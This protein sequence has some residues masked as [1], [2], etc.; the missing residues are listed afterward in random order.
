VR[1]ACAE[2]AARYAL[3]VPRRRLR[4]RIGDALGSGPGASV[5]FEDHRDY[6]I[7]DDPRHID[8]RAYARS[9]RLSVRVW[10]EEVAPALDLVVDTSASMAVSERK[11]RAAR[12]LVDAVAGW[13]ARDGAALR[14]FAAG[15]DRLAGAEALA[16]AGPGTASLAPRDT[17]RPRG[18]RVVVSDFLFEEDPAP[19]LRRLV[20]G[21]AHVFVIQL[22]DPDE[23]APD[24]A[25]LAVTLVD[26]ERGGR[27]DLYLD[28][29]TVA[30]YSKRLMRLCDGVAVASRRLG[31]TY[32][33]V[34]A[35]EPRAMFD[36]DLLPQGV[37]QPA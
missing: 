17:L 20:A 12:D 8:W 14:V 3:A 31:A 30:A 19:A 22:L 33:R 35:G 11:E 13:S 23:I 27:H 28:D 4:G 34:T 5:E 6:A 21:A 7:G 25:R 10:R 37:V 16:F 32:A 18:L 9:D 1:P 26:C 15:G 24:P 36:H 2:A 29:A